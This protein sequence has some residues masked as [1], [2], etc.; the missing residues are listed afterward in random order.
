[1]E[2]CGGGYLVRLEDGS[3]VF[4]RAVIVATGARY[5]RLDIPELPQFEGISVY[6]AAT[7]V[8]AQLCA[9]APR[10]IASSHSR[11]RSSRVG[12]KCPYRSKVN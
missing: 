5:R 7:Q 10:H 1:L 11:S 6:Y 9:G 2:R 3:S 4:T 12:S 8:E